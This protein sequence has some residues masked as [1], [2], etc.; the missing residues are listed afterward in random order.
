MTIN[1]HNH[2]VDWE[3]LRALLPDWGR[4]L[5]F[6]GVGI[7]DINLGDHRDRL[8]DW[9]ADEYHGEMEYMAR[10]GS[11][12]W[13]P[14]RLHPG[15]HSIIT[16]RIDYL[17]KQPAPEEVL[18]Q[19]DKAYISRYALGRDYHKVIRNK[20]KQLVKRIKDHC[21]NLGF[22]DFDS[23]VF[24]DSA[25]I[26][27]KALAEKS[28]LGWIG[29]HTLLI[30]EKEGSWFFLGEILTN[31]PLPQSSARQTNRC[32]SCTACI[33]ICPT[34]AIVAPYTLD[35]RR[36]ISYLTI[37]HRGVIPLEFRKPMGNRVFGCD[38]CQL[39]C[40]WNRYA[41]QTTEPDF[42]PRHGLGSADLL[43]L[44]SW[45]EEEFLKNTEGSAIRRTGY[46]GWLRNLA[47]GL[48]NII[49]KDSVSKESVSKDSVSK[50]SDAGKTVS[51]QDVTDALESRKGYS[52][53]VDHHIEWAIS[54][55]QQA[56]SSS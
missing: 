44:F 21:E 12:R 32:G 18:A 7:S 4:E 39:T 29:K 8:K 23:R 19:G 53:L 28:G 51:R 50:D 36:C 48:G 10:H 43:H 15:T 52:T 20:L 27:E 1:H 46:E 41:N 11:M 9:L 45:S 34:K 24:T 31:L 16:V 3:A 49:S 14:E 5:G 33:D 13:Q 40:P 55:H 37:E 47:I 26:L 6:S 38:D 22:H 25:P 54:Q 30:N 2:N 42:E 35:A 56:I 17:Q